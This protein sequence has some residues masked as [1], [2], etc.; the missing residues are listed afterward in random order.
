M[1]FILKVQLGRGEINDLTYNNI[2]R[3]ISQKVHGKYCQPII[4]EL[5]EVPAPLT[6][7][8]ADLSTCKGYEHCDISQ[9][10][11]EFFFLGTTWM[12]GRMRFCRI[13]VHF[14]MSMHLPQDRGRV[15][16]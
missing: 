15:S 6:A 12:L 14:T 16:A 13:S 11:I 1:D 7:Q 8:V 2:T 9:Q 5:V 10:Q 4:F 3:V